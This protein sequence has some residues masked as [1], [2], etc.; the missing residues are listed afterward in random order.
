MSRAPDALTAWR[1]IPALVRAHAEG[2]SDEQLDD[3]ADPDAMTVREAVHHVAEANVVAAGIVVAALGRPGST[4]D[5]SWLQPSGPW[6]DNMAYAGK[7]VD[8]ALR[9]IDAIVEYVAV[10]LAPLRDGLQ[11]TVLLV[12]APAAR[13]RRTTVA[14]VL[15]AE[16]EHA[17]VHLAPHDPPRPASARPRRPRRVT[18]RRRR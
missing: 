13:P 3:R 4:F 8:A 15:L 6:F 12:D 9:L 18:T 5:W 10:Q 1:T 7:P 2:R 11:R 16:V 17:R 14:K